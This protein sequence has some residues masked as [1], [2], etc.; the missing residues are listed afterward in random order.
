MA[1]TESV[2]LSNVIELGTIDAQ[3]TKDKLIGYGLWI[4]VSSNDPDGIV[5]DGLL[6]GDNLAVTFAEG[7]CSFAAT[8]LSPIA[9]VVAVV[10]AVTAVGLTVVSDGAFAFAAPAFE[11]A[12]TEISK[13]FVGKK[14]DNKHRDVFGAD[15]NGAFKHVE[16]GVV[17]CMPE[18]KSTIHSNSKT[19]PGRDDA[20]D[21]DTRGRIVKYTPSLVKDDYNSFFL[22]RDAVDGTMEG[23]VKAGSGEAVLLAF[24]KSDAFDDNSGYYTLHVVITRS[25]SNPSEVESRFTTSGVLR[26]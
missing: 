15:P 14:S 25:G 6:Q 12:T 9:G 7:V 16:G 5:I 2:Q 26:G 10:G 4:T 8:D 20:S 18:A 13:Y 19:Q 17:V 22:C 21:Y 23:T 1:A 3:Y 24:D 11:T